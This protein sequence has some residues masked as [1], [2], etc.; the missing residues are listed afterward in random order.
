MIDNFDEFWEKKV[1]KP[2]NVIVDGIAFPVW[3]ERNLKVYGDCLIPNGII[4]AF[5]ID[6]VE[7]AL[8]KLCNRHVLVNVH[9]GY[10]KKDTSYIAVVITKKIKNGKK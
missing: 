4:N 9:R 8:K 2:V 10:S 6:R 3:I 1:E 7:K 5:G